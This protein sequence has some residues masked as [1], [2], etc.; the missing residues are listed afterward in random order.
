MDFELNETEAMLREGVARFARTDGPRDAVTDWTQAVTMGWTAAATPEAQ[1]GFG[2]G[3][4][5]PMLIAE[6]LGAGLSPLVWRDLAVL[7]ALA[8]GGL[9]ERGDEAS[10]RWLDAFLAGDLTPIFA[11]LDAVP[12]PQSVICP[13]VPGGLP[14][15]LALLRYRDGDCDCL[16]MAGDEAIQ[17]D[18]MTSGRITVAVDNGRRIVIPPD[19]AA[20]LDTAAQIVAAADHMGVM[21]ALMDMTLEYV[22]TRRQFGRPLGAFQALQHRLVDMSIALEEARALTMAAAMAAGEARHDTPRL[23]AAAWD[24][25]RR[26][27]KRIA[28]ES[29]QLHGG[30]GMTEECLVGA[31]VKRILRNEWS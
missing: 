18:D 9:A 7:P 5:G 16:V 29:I 27:G 6:E 28:E 21:R 30:I 26:A 3:L 15:G 4:V 14:I 13:E 10:F 22:R 1:G 12:E 17:T 8:L 23:A 24:C 19:L 31:Y 25:T 2:L 11:Q 20:Q